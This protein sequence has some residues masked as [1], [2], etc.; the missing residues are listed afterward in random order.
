[1]IVVACDGGA[2]F[3]SLVIEKRLCVF[4]KDDHQICYVHF[5]S[6]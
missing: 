5:A 1:M 4:G 6:C 2:A 3:T